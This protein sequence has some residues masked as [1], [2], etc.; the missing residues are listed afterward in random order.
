MV[1]PEILDSQTHASDLEILG[2]GIERRTD[3]LHKRAA[4]IETAEQYEDLVNDKSHRKLILRYLRSPTQI[5][6]DEEGAISG[7]K[8]QRNVLYGE[9]DHQ[10]TRDYES[11]LGVEID[12]AFEEVLSNLDC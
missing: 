11:G 1:K 8:M 10:K 6:T 3:F 7:L 12:P 2:R 5:K 4:L 9:P